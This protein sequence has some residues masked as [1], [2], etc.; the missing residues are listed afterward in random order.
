[1]NDPAVFQFKRI[2]DRL[3]QD[4][5]PVHV[6]MS[7]ASCELLMSLLLE[8]YAHP[9]IPDAAADNVMGLAK[10]LSNIIEKYHPESEPYLAFVFGAAVF[11]RA[12]V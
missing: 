3:M 2:I 11:Q 10:A 7:I 1:M 8:W 4:D 5:H 6:E 12:D 9:D